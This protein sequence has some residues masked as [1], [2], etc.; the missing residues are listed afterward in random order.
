MLMG[1]FLGSWGA[2]LT[3]S[4]VIGLLIGMVA[5]RRA[6]ADPRALR[7]L[8]ARRPDRLRLRAELPRA[9]HHRLLLR[10]RL[11]R[12]RARRTNIPRVP[13]VA[14]PAD[15]G[16]PVLRRHLRPAEPA[17]LAR[18]ACSCC[19]PGW[20][21]SARR[22]GCGCA[23]WARTRWRRRPPASRRSCGCATWRSS[24]LGRARRRRRRVPVDRLRR[25][26]SRENMT[27]GRGFIALA[28]LICG[29][30]RPSGA[31][32]AALPVRLLERARPAPAGVLAVRPRRCSRR[33]RTCSR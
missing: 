18:A 33:C 9:R 29:R 11:R 19:S 7:R 20:S 31:L 23:R 22:R 1:A 27:A 26:R 12:R 2:E 13:D 15:R 8:A 14:A 28:V 25:T 10:Q 3:G 6:G 24:R 16:H 17:D 32:A 30:W 4:W 21:C 5:G